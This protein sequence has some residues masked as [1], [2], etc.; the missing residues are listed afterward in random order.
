MA[1]EQERGKG[2]TQQRKSMIK[3]ARERGR[4]QEK[5]G[6]GTWMRGKQNLN[7]HLDFE[8][9]PNFGWNYFISNYE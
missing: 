7:Y 2:K 8:F 9:H 3:I 4:E 6:D 1:R 5:W